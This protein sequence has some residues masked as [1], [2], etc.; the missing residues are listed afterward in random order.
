MLRGKILPLMFCFISSLTNSGKTV[1]W[2]PFGSL[3]LLY[4][5][6]YAIYEKKS[7]TSVIYRLLYAVFVASSE[8]TTVAELAQTLQAKPEQL[9]S[10]VSLASRLGW[11]KKFIDPAAFLQDT[12]SEYSIGD[13]RLISPSSSPM[14]YGASE[15]S[16]ADLLRGQSGSTRFAFMVDANLTSYLMMGSLSPG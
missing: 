7:Q 12:V 16:D 14:Y 4:P 9:Q 11:A 3:L 15:P 6:L 5:L 8:Q 10:A 2:I 1:K 13:D